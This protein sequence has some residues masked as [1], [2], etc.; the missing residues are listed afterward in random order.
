VL[1][2]DSTVA[3]SCLSIEELGYFDENKEGDKKDIVHEKQR[4]EDSSK[5]SGEGERKEK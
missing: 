5:N 1:S 2:I 4:S 3:I